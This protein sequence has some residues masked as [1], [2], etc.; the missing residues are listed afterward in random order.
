[1]ARAPYSKCYTEHECIAFNLQISCLQ[2]SKIKV[3][4]VMER[5]EIYKLICYSRAYFVYIGCLLKSPRYT[6]PDLCNIND[7]QILICVLLLESWKSTHQSGAGRQIFVCC[8][9][10]STYRSW[11]KDKVFIANKVNKKI[12]YRILAQYLLRTLSQV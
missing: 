2:I 3:V 9:D 10:L 7:P 1:M 6:E 4:F 11:T 12:I 5:L 8:T